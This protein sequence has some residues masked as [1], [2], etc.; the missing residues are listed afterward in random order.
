MQNSLLDKFP[1]KWRWTEDEYCILPPEELAQITPLSPEKAK[2]AWSKSLTFISSQS[3]F[4]PNTDLFES[5]E[6]IDTKDENQVS[7]WLMRKMT[8]TD[9]IV[10]WQPEIAVFTNS[11]LF[12]KYWDEFCY[13]SSDDVSI[14]PKDESWVIHFCHHEAF[15][16]GRAKSI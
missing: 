9:I 7:D 8:S 14:W 10:S 5:I 15:C 11:Q 4:S 3:D 6:V 13:P 12:I 1:L 16:Y 2:V